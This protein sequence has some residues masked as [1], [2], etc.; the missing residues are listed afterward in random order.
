MSAP[1]PTAEVEDAE[2]AWKKKQ[3]YRKVGTVSSRRLTAF[4][5]VVD[6]LTQALMDAVQVVFAFRVRDGG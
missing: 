4:L 2:S 5:R 6:P 3:A 1:A